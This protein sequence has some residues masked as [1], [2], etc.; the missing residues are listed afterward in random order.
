[1]NPCHPS[2]FHSGYVI[3]R[4]LRGEDEAALAETEKHLPFI[5]FWNDVVVAAVLARLGRIGEARRH[6]ERVLEVKPDFPGRARELLRLSLKIDDLVDELISALERV[7]L[8]SED[9]PSSI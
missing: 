5:D 8:A 2:W 3:A 7:G 6:S 9:R 1:M 4:L